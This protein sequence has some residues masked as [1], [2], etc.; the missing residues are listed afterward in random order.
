MTDSARVDT[1]IT[2]HVGTI[3]LNQPAR[4]NAMRTTMW[5]GLRDAVAELVAD[6]EVR[7]IVVR[8]TGEIAFCAGAD[9]S[10]FGQSRTDAA[11]A[12]AAEGVAHEAIHSLI[13]CAVPTIARVRGPCVGA[14]VEIALACDIRIASASAR[15]GV[16]P[17]K[18]GLGYGLEDTQL[19]VDRLGPSA[20]REI[21]FTGRIYDSEN[22]LRLGLVNVVVDEDTLD[23]AVESYAHDIA[24]NAPLTVRASKQII[25]QSLR[26]AEARDTALCKRLQAQCYASADFEE[27]RA[28]FAAKR[29]PQFSGV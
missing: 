9:I 1:S 19:L 13:A 2:G 17:A 12:A 21:L 11:A 3:S 15:C 28:A 7:V 14:G 27:G 8:G 6:S 5:G 23:Q 16:T 10:E 26:P 20:A 25:E 24:T 18:L 22:S 29:P 4:R